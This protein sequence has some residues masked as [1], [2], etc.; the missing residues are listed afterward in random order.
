M[1][2]N[3]HHESVAFR[4]NNSVGKK[5]DLLYDDERVPVVIGLNFS[6][7]FKNIAIRFEF[8]FMTF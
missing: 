5:R 4:A 7:E 6:L 3:S 2:F 1:A 8:K